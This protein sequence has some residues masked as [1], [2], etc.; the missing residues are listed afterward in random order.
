MFA[1]ISN[2]IT[3]DHLDKA[4]I[5]ILGFRLSVFIIAL[6]ILEQEYERIARST[7]PLGRSKSFV[8]RSFIVWFGSQTKGQRE[9]P[10][11][12]CVSVFYFTV[13]SDFKSNSSEIINWLNSY[14]I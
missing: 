14:V 8:E 2:S 6:Y 4:C 12:T 11:A 9:T 3:V 5:P 7:T 1:R 10:R 13:H